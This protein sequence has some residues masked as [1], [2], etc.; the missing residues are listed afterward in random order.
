[1]AKIIPSALISQIVGKSR[2]SC[3]QMWK[4][5]NVMR[6][7]PAPKSNDRA[8]AALYRTIVSEIAGSHYAMT[9][10]QK[11]AWNSYAALLPDDMSGFNAFMA[12]NVALEYAGN[13]CLHFYTNAPTIYNPPAIPAPIN[14]CYYPDTNK[15]CISWTTPSDVNTF[16]QGFYAPQAGY[17]NQSFAKFRYFGLVRADALHIEFDASDYPAETM[18][19]FTVRAINMLG[20]LSSITEINPPPPLPESVAVLS[21]NG[22]EWYYYGQQVSITWRSK[23]ID[24]LSLYYSL[25]NGSS[26]NLIS[27]SV[28]GDTGSYTWT[29]PSV[30]S[31]LGLIKLVDNED[32]DVHDQS[33]AVFEITPVPTLS[34]TAPIG[35]ESWAALSEQSI[36]WTENDIS[37]LSLYYSINNGSSWTLIQSGVTASDLTYSWTLPDVDSALCLVRLVSDDDPDLLSTSPAVFEIYPA[38]PS[39]DPIASWIF[40]TSGYDA[41]NTRFTDQTGNGHHFTN[42]GA[43]VGSDYTD[44]NGSS[45][46]I[47]AS[48]F[49]E[50]SLD[51]TKFSMAVWI[52]TSDENGGILGHWGTSSGNNAWFNYLLSGNFISLVDKLGDNSVKKRYRSNINIHDGSW[53]MVGFSFNNNTFKVYIDGAEDTGTNKDY[54]NTMTTIRNSTATFKGCYLA[55]AGYTIGYLTCQM[56]KAWFWNDELPA[57]DFELLF[58]VGH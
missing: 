36:T 57:S 31:S 43:D 21:P 13:V 47:E 10:N 27:G 2:G 29:I 52:K 8:S 4:G 42:N 9:A 26:W 48:D 53:H 34:I 55:A 37:T 50:T 32:S 58:N 12:R 24:T 28:V 18:I 41:G 40:K 19:R 51:L 5:K 15:Y 30:T 49:T 3:F 23:N 22:G 46:F 45:D 14:L 56:S 16:V 54:D 6:S 33:N 11:I 1:M 17:S 7:S 44:F 35:G 39:I 38:E 20:E 25:D